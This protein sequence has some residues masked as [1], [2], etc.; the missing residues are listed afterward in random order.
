MLEFHLRLF[1]ERLKRVLAGEEGTLPLPDS[2]NLTPLF[3]NLLTESEIIA[4]TLLEKNEADMAR[5][6]FQLIR[7]E[8][9]ES[10]I[11]SPFLQLLD[12]E[13]SDEE[14]V[15][16][17]DI[18][19]ILEDIN[20]FVHESEE[21]I[22][23]LFINIMQQQ[24]SENESESSTNMALLAGL[25]SKI[26]DI[27]NRMQQLP[28]GDNGFDISEKSNE[29]IRLLSEGQPRLDISEFE[30]G[31][32]KFFD[33]LIEGPSGLSV[34]AIL[35]SSGFD[36]TAFAADTYNNNHVKFYFDC[37]AWV[38]VSVFYDFRMILDDIIKS[39]MPPSRVSVII[40]EDY[41]FKESILRDYLTNRKYFIV[42]DDV[43][44]NIEIWDDLEEVLPDNQNGS[45]V[46]ILVTDPDLLASLEMENGEKIRLAS[47]LIGGPLIR[48]KHEAWQFFVLHHGSMPLENYVQGEAI[49]T[50]WRQIFSVMELPFHLKVCCIY[51]CVFP[52]GIEIST[53]QLYQ[54]WVA[55]GFIPY[56][57]EETAEHY[58]KEL[59]HRGFIQV[60]KR[61]AG[62]TIKAC[63]VPSLAYTPM[64][65][66]AE[67]TG[68]VWMPEMEGGSVAYVKRCFILDDLIDF[69]SLKHS[70]MYLQSFMNHS[71]ESDRLALIDCENFCKKF[72]HLRVLNL[73][74]AVLDQYP[75]GLGNLYLLKY[76]KLNIP[77]L[78]CLPSLLCTLLN[79]QTL[80]MPSSYID[81]SPEDIWMMQKLMHLNFGSITLP[82]PPKNYSSSLKNLIF[83]SALNPSSCTPD[84]LGRLPSVRTLPIS[85][86]L[87]YYQSGVSKSLC[88]LHKLECLKLVNESKPSRMVLSEYQFPPSLIQLSLSNTELMEDPMP[89]LENLPRLRVLKLKQN[90]YLGRKLACVGLSSFPVLKV[91]HLKSMYWLDEWTMGAGA[92]PKLESLIV[93]PCAYL[94]K[95]PEELWCIKSLRKLN[96]HWPQ[97]ELRQTLRTFEDMEWRELWDDLEELLPN[98]QNGS[99]VLILVADLDLLA[100]LEMENGEKIRL[101]SVLVGGPLIRLKHEAWQF[102]ILHYGTCGIYL[103][104][105]PPSIKISTRQLRQ[106]WIAEGFIQY[107]SEETAE[108]Y[109]K[110]LIHRGFF[111]VSKRRAGGTIKACYVPSLVY[112]SLL[113]VA[114]KTRFVLMPDK[115]EESLAN[116]KRCFILEDLI[117]F[118]FLEQS[119]ILPNV[120][121]LR[122]SG[123]L[124]CYH[125]GVSNSLLGLHKL[126]C[127]KLVN[128][129]KLS[130]VVLSKYQFPLSLSHLSLSNTELMQDPMPIMEK[131]PRLQVLKLKQNSYLGR[132]LA[133]VG[134]SS[135]PKLT[136]LHLKSM[137]WQDEWTMGAGAMPKLESLI[138]N[139]CAYL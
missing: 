127:L 98:N 12:L 28:P 121:T 25:H 14:V 49:P 99:R 18:F 105:F 66:V 90:S 117:E 75:P 58:L 4:T 79:L 9:D 2:T 40:G 86:D 91:L 128:E 23:T 76:L 137:Y 139:P 35:D 133:C 16:T 1:C 95:L 59:I 135:F 77:S 26:I 97:T 110:E 27:S 96:L 60:S 114:E 17:A 22:D 120:Q 61:R 68:F 48:L 44:D 72:K 13:E 7:E 53:R 32:E 31:R 3:Q 38:R 82:A 39:V 78:K 45:R 46:L 92:M 62:G 55:E 63:Y 80:E 57:D 102:F 71:S 52:P 101:N 64:V 20:D 37:L 56:N 118:I 33:L 41:Q 109:L 94:R 11:S 81:Q 115:E 116:V 123:D 93:N 107:N 19:E 74:S 70:D 122:I 89:I 119:G 125:S 51:L 54:L 24:N 136:V 84:I 30:R 67:K 106:L 111:Q 100:S 138:V 85:G 42:L 5:H 6:L 103:C 88:E 69:F 104:V 8:F 113:L 73:G 21:A 29:I 83:I 124:S 131:L 10:K 112:Y 129:S 134:S 126:E 130:R 87:S 65:L 36:R 47:V 34:V 50:V 43:C 132:K 15:E 108:H